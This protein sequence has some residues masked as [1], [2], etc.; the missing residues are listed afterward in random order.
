MLLLIRRRRRRRRRIWIRL[1][2][3]PNSLLVSIYLSINSNSIYNNNNNQ[4]YLLLFFVEAAPRLTSEDIDF[5]QRLNAIKRYQIILFLHSGVG[6]PF[7]CSDNTLL[8]LGRHLSKRRQK[9]K[10]NL[11]QL[12]MM[13][14]FLFLQ[15]T[16]QLPS[17]PRYK[18]S[19]LSHKRIIFVRTV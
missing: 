11:E 2:C 10:K 12:T 16:K 15:T 19:F 14:L 4:F 3:L 1:L 18:A 6:T 8:F 5:Q 7:T 17:V 9:R 13:L